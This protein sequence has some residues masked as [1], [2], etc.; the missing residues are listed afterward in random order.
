MHS[1][2]AASGTSTGRFDVT[3]AFKCRAQDLFTTLLEEG[4][5]QAAV[6]LCL[7]PL[8]ALLD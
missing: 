5:S 7:S 1:M 4:V 3:D 6:S 8:L 2:D